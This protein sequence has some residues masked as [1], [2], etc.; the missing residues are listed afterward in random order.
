VAHVDHL[1]QSCAQQIILFRVGFLGF[2]S[3]LEIAG[4]W[5]Q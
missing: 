1:N 5:L 3:Q 4:F 2:I